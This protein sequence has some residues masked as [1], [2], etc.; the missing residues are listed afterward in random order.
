MFT[1]GLR[2]PRRATLGMA[3]GPKDRIF[4]NRNANIRNASA[5][6]P[7]LSRTDAFASV[8]DAHCAPRGQAKKGWQSLRSAAW[9]ALS[10]PICV[11]D[12]QLPNCLR[13]FLLCE[14]IPV[15]I[16]V[17]CAIKIPSGGIVRGLEDQIRSQI[18]EPLAR[19]ISMNDRVQLSNF[20]QRSRIVSALEINLGAK[21]MN[22]E[23]SRALFHGLVN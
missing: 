23:D 15:V 21:C 10:A 1:A 22:V 19:R 4:A 16:Y 3:K 2:R 9:T 11:L 13:C 8:R 6:P 12:L 18:G 7:H 14:H 5:L 17:L 20:F